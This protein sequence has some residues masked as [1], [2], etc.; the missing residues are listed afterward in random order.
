MKEIPQF[1]VIAVWSL[2][3]RVILW[4]I[5]KRHVMKEIIIDTVSVHSLAY[6][7]DFRVMFTAGYENPINMWSFETS[8]CY[9]TGQLSGHNA[10]V[11]AIEVIK[12]TPL[13]VSADE[14]GFI[15]TWDIRNMACFQTIHF[16]SKGSL[17]SFLYVNSKKMVGADIRLH[18]FEFDDPLTVNANGIE[19][20]NI[21]PVAAQFS[22]ANDELLIATKRDIR[23]VDIFNGK[24]K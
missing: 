18:W 15:K 7:V 24:I 20:K 23:I 2:D 1:K 17:K 14:I 10:Q 12:D 21:T 8:D 22:E 19:I 4:D 5:I 16:E 13:L 9:H 3:K 11:T 6:S